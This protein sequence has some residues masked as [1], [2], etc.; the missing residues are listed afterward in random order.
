[1]DFSLN[2][3]QRMIADTARKVGAQFDLGY[4]RDHDARKAFP[5]EFWQAVCGAGL[6]GVALP[7][8]NGGAGLGMVE[9]A[10]VVEELSA[11]AGGSTVGQLFMINP[12]FGGVSV[13]RFGTPEMRNEVLPKIIRGEIICCMAL[14]EPDAGSNSLEIQT[15]A[16]ANGNGW[17]LNGRKIW[18]SGVDSAHKMLVV[19][20]TK[21]LE[22]SSSRTDG[23]SMFLID[24]DRKGVSHAPIEKLGTN[25]LAAS[26]VYFED[27]HIDGSELIGTL[28]GGWYEL[29]E[30]LNTERIVTS[31]G[32]VGAGNLAIRQAVEYA[33]QRKVFAGAPIAA[34]Q[35]LQFPLAQAHAEL[36]SARLMNLQAASLCDSGQPYGSEANIAKLLAAQAAADATERSMQVLG[37]MG[38]A[39]D[40]HIERL[41]RDARLF[42]FAP[43]SEEMILNFIAMQNLGLPRSY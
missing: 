37:G 7:P 26:S 21:K 9:M 28:H 35:G 16:S 14:T 29:L 36:A 17:K 33:K 42:R 30:V 5:A 12:I 19:A 32:L 10:I 8:E 1:M 15:F 40:S 20:R 39:K 6:C 2:E 25:T 11:S 31:A 18:I 24:C 4:W 27:V 43:I 3:E 13:S 41:W 38:Y 23:I 22:N 34:Y